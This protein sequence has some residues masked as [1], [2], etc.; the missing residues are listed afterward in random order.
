MNLSYN[1]LL[2]PQQL[3]R[4]LKVYFDMKKDDFTTMFSLAKELLWAHLITNN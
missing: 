3:N 2:A 4:M 1:S